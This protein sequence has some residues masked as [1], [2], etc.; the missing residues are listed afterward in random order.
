MVSANST[1]K[2]ILQM[3]ITKDINKAIIF[4]ARNHSSYWFCNVLRVYSIKAFYSFGILF[5]FDTYILNVIVLNQ[6]VKLILKNGFFVVS[7]IVMKRDSILKLKIFSLK[8]TP[9]LSK[10][11][12]ME[13]YL[14]VTNYNKQQK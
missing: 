11:T 3:K 7:K 14:N 2:E 13:S 10:S 9:A 4:F 8:L 6:V 12:L 5:S 1:M